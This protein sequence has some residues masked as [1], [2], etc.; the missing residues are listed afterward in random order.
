MTGVYSTREQA[1]AAIRML[2]ASLKRQG[3]WPRTFASIQASVAVAS[4]Q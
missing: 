4:E 1:Q 3:P 2:P